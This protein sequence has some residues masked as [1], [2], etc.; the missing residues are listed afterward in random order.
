MGGKE[1]KLATDRS[2]PLSRTSAVDPFAEEHCCQF[3]V[4]GPFDEEGCLSCCCY[5]CNTFC[6]TS[7]TMT[8]AA[9]S[10][11]TVL[12]LSAL[13]ALVLFFSPFQYNSTS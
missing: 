8:L 11:T 7:N 5:C 10:V 12:M 13:V 3:C 6:V 9:A 2:D 4:C 1:S